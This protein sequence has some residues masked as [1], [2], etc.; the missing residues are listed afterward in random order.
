MLAK[1]DHKE[2]GRRAGNQRVETPVAEGI[3]NE[4]KPGYKGIPVTE[5]RR[6]YP[7][8]EHRDWNAAEEG[9]GEANHGQGKASS[10]CKVDF[11]W[12]R[13]EQ[14]G[15]IHFFRHF[16]RAI[17]GSGVCKVASRPGDFFKREIQCA[18][19]ALFCE[20]LHASLCSTHWTNNRIHMRQGL[21]MK[22]F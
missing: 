2:I 15:S 20:M 4:Y 1:Y 18:N 13:W 16:K 17:E 14:M 5:R 10:S 9:Y 8:K 19:R 12:L 7:P 22:S 11:P 3:I 6:F 21:R